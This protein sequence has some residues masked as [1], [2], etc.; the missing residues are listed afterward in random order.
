MAQSMPYSSDTLKGKN[1]RPTTRGTKIA[2]YRAWFP[3]RAVTEVDPYPHTLALP[4][5]S[6]WTP[7]YEI[8]TL[9]GANEL[10]AVISHSALDASGRIPDVSNW[11][12][13]LWLFGG[14]ES[15]HDGTDQRRWA[16]VNC[17]VFDS[18]L[19]KTFSE[20]F[21][22]GGYLFAMFRINAFAG[23]VDSYLELLLRAT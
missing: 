13:E 18:M 17:A 1:F 15:R 20:R 5:D 4:A 6:P 23:E 8:V 19:N 7:G 9:K 12:G 22:V 16:R 21:D 3:L 11:G 10:E 14:E 2:H